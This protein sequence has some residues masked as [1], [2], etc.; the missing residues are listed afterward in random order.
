MNNSL[1][2]I[3]VP[4][5]NTAEYLEEC[6]ESVLNQTYKNIELILI[7]DGSTDKSGEICKNYADKYPIKYIFQ[8]NQGV[9]VARNNGLDVATGKYVYFLDSDDS[10]DSRFIETSVDVAEK[11]NTDIVI[12]ACNVYDKIKFGIVF[13]GTPWQ[14]F[15]KKSVIDKIPLRF[16]VGICTCED[17]LFN[18]MLSFWTNKISVNED[19]IYYYRVRPDSATRIVNSNR[20]ANDM[21]IIITELEKFCYLYNLFETKKQLLTEI[22]FWYYVG[23]C[24]YTQLDNSDKKKIFNMTKAFIAKHNLP[25]NKI[26]TYPSVRHM[27]ICQFGTRILI[28]HCKTFKDFEKYLFFVNIYKKLKTMFRMSFKIKKINEAKFL[29]D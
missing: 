3:I 13:A 16:V 27:D 17:G 24:M 22:I 10:I 5:Y 11:E 18:Q 6:I 7:N 14:L 28:L 19:A 25:I 26:Y 20:I 8:P 12:V 29:S 1:V 15:I 4:V 2:S 21:Q 23:F 9:S